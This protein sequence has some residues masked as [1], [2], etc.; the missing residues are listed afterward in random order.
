MQTL[1]DDPQ[2]Q[3]ILKRLTLL[4]PAST[5][6]WGKMSPAQMLAHCSLALEAATGDRPM[7]QK[8]IGK[9]LSPLVRSSAVGSDKPFGKSSPT[10]PTFVVS[11]EC[12]FSAERERLRAL[13]VRFAERGPSE[14]A[15][16]VH[17]F[18]GRLDGPEWGR[19]MYK[20]LDHHL[21]QFGV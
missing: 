21:R 10:D 7:K 5:R 16:Q 4:E 18:F 8:L 20:H 19:L 3:S 1:F 2:R 9:I 15:R 6:Q 14:A 11:H 12:D 17:A 13:V